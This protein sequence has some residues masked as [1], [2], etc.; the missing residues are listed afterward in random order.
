MVQELI[1]LDS[2]NSSLLDEASAGGEAFYLA[3]NI[4]NG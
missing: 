4:H 2:S 1:G 3:Y